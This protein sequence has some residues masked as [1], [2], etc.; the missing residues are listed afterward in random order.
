MFNLVPALIS[1]Y[2]NTGFYFR[3]C[4]RGFE[5]IGTKSDFKKSSSMVLFLVKYIL[6]LKV[7]QK[8]IHLE[9]KE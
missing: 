5:S 9:E 4:S 8:M 1:D 6:N 3:I 7:Q 2:L